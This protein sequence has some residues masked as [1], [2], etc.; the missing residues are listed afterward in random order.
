VWL[1]KL[2][3]E[4]NHRRWF[5]A[6]DINTDLGG[7]LEVS[8]LSIRPAVLNDMNLLKTLIHEMGEYERLPVMITEET[9]ARDGFGPRPEFRVLIADWDGQA[10]GYAFFFNCYS[11]FR[12]RGLFLEDL[13]VRPQF[14]GKKVGDALLSH[15]A[16]VA[17][18]GAYF[19]IM[20]NVLGWNQPAIEFFRKHGATFLDDWKTACLDGEALQIL[21]TSS[22]LSAK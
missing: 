21:Q 7:A 19:G 14:R 15:L 9:L 5:S 13:F 6:A 17:G 2:L 10:A 1:L 16:A 4:L 8:M 18:E 11:T 20:L 12:G 3:A 22:C